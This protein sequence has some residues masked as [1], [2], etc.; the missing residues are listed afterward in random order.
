VDVSISETLL[1]VVLALWLVVS[2]LGQI[3]VEHPDSRFQRLRTF[4]PF[5]LIPVW[6]FFA[7]RPAWTDYHLLYRDILPDGH[8]T[9]WTEL[10]TVRPRRVG[11]I[12]WHP[13]KHC[14]KALIDLIRTFTK[15]LELVAGSR[16][17]GNDP[18]LPPTAELPASLFM[19]LS[20][21]TILQAVSSA[22]RFGS[23]VSTQFMI[24]K[25]DRAASPTPKAMLVSAVHE[26]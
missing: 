17:G 5:G 25:H 10:F 21:L 2:V 8:A 7:P 19:S 3:D 23:A 18:E 6:T 16:A 9:A 11:H 14:R 22:P 24:L 15:E 1:G 13:D 26:L 20:Y 12:F 4:D